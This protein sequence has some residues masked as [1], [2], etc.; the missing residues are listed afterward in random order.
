MRRE[1][2]HCNALNAGVLK[3]DENGGLRVAARLPR[4]RMSWS[5]NTAP[6][7]V[8]PT[9]GSA[10]SILLAEIHGGQFREP[11]RRLILDFAC[12]LSNHDRTSRHDTVH[13]SYARSPLDTQ[14]CD[15]HPGSHCCKGGTHLACRRPALPEF[16]AH[17]SQRQVQ[18]TKR[19]ERKAENDKPDMSLISLCFC[20]CQLD[21]S[22]W[23]TF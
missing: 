4:C 23:L 17:H 10:S 2:R 7:R 3:A 9:D 13:S 14:R 1:G 18:C 16:L 11:I 20:S 8:L 5:R 19:D 22:F 12:S 21:L 6:K 15:R